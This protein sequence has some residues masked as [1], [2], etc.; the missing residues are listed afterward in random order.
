MLVTNQASIS[1]NVNAVFD[2]MSSSSRPAGTASAMLAFDETLNLSMVSTGDSSVLH[3]IRTARYIEKH[4][5]W[6]RRFCRRSDDL[7]RLLRRPRK[8]PL[9]WAAR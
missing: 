2:L 3:A 8:E 7:A 4:E 6:M 1:R 5:L 9:H